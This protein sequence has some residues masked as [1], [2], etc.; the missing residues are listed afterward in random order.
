MARRFGERLGCAVAAGADEL[1]EQVRPDFAF[2]LGRHADMAA[3]ARILIERKIPFVVEKPAGLDAA[4]VQALAGAATAAGV[5]AAVPLVFRSSGFMSTL[6]RE[7]AGE[8]VLYADF[9]FVAG[10]PS[11]YHE[12]GCPWMFD[13]KQAGG[14]TLVNLGV[15]FIDL[16]QCLTSTVGTRLDAASFAA[17][18]REGDVEDY[19]T[20]TLRNGDRIGRVET[21]YLYPAPAGI[22]DMHFSVRTEKHYVRTLG[23]GTIE[24][25][26]LAGGRRTVKGTTTNMPIYPAFVADV[27]DRVRRAESPVADLHDMANVMAVVEQAYRIGRVR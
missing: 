19:V 2:V 22:F 21:A 26:D 9:K 3:A 7:A 18:Q 25:S 15:H 6:R 11:R 12:A 5:F 1:C 23:P 16:F 8:R 13:R 4:Q 10:L 20:L 27:L 17:L 14:G 24:V